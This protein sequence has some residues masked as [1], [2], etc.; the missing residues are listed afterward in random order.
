MRT[1]GEFTHV[2]STHVPLLTPPPPR[3][4]LP[5][6]RLV[7]RQRQRG[8]DAKTTNLRGQTPL[9]YAASKGHVA[10]GRAL[11]ETGADVNARDQAQQ[12]AL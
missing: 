6:V 4:L 3:F 11:M 8:A 5:R 2:A 1:R 7:L 9:H 12:V 10:V